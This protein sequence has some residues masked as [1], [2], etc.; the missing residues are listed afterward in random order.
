M[1]DSWSSSWRADRGSVEPSAVSAVV[2]V[3]VVVLGVASRHQGASLRWKTRAL[4]AECDAV[5]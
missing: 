2:V 4:A 5:R 1:R 3:V